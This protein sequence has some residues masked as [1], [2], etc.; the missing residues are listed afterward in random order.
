MTPT[1][2]ISRLRAGV[3]VG[4]ATATDQTQRLY[5]ELIRRNDCPELGDQGRLAEVLRQLG[6]RAAGYE[7]DVKAYARFRQKA[8]R[9]GEPQEPPVTRA[10][11]P[12]E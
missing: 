11:D 3:S 10:A 4:P 12:A 9:A 1:E 6:K 7:A 8:A 5:A 2:R